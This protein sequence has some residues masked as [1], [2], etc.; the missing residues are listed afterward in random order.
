LPACSILFATGL[1]P[2]SLAGWFLVLLALEY[3]AQEANR[4]L[5]AMSEQVLASIVLF[6]RQGL[7]ALVA[8]SCMCLNS[9]ARNLTFVFY[10]W[11]TG[12]FASFVLASIHIQS[13]RIFHVSSP[14]DWIWIK[15]GLS[16]SLPFFIGTISM[17]AIYTIDRY[18]IERICGLDALAAYVFFMS[19]ANAIF[20]FLDAS[21]FSFSYPKLIST[22]NSLSE[23]SFLK[24]VK[25]LA[26][27]TV[28]LSI[29]LSAVVL[30]FIW[31]VLDF[32]QKPVY[33]NNIS[34][35]YLLILATVFL[36]FSMVPHYAL[37]ARH[38][39]RSI[40]LSHILSLP[41][42]VIAAIS[43]YPVLHASAVPAGLALSF[44]FLFLFKSFVFCSNLPTALFKPRS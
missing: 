24:E 20:S 6:I 26:F 12:V 42:F 30:V 13:F 32:L 17:Q 16:I 9:D 38:K 11:A 21:V 36:S 19:I 15:R 41:I 10:I 37:I 5:V 31:P 27:H 35:L 39:D 44:L 14:I 4:L 40:F 33:L 25:S 18:L 7:W 34:F 22:G 23:A 3:A 29:G 2:W 1:L 8:F 43:L 28:V